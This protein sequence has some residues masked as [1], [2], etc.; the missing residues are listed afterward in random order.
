[1]AVQFTALQLVERLFKKHNTT[2]APKM[3]KREI[4]LNY[5]SIWEQ[6]QEAII[7]KVKSEFKGD[8]IDV[9]L[10]PTPFI[11]VRQEIVD[12]GEILTD[13]KDYSAPGPDDDYTF[14]SIDDP[15]PG[16][17]GITGHLARS[18]MPP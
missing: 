17:A 11:Y 12:H 4:A 16:R 9:L 14:R 18:Q 6:A 3:L 8:G 5:I 1:M 2:W 13:D 15:D 10:E 7:K